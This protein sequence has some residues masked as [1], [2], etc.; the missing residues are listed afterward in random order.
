MSFLYRSTPLLRTS[1]TT[2]TSQSTRCF[3]TSLAQRNVVKDAAKKVDRTVSDQLVKGIDK[4]IEAKDA[5]AEVA[6]VDTQKA[7]AKAEE[8]KGDAKA[9]GE[10]MKGQ[11]NAA[12]EEAKAKI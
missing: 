7:K 10:Q 8:L 9:K 3:S 5:V 6:G 1:A 2:L 4:G 11:A 12:K